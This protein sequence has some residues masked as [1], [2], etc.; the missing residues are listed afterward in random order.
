MTSKTSNTEGIEHSPEEKISEILKYAKQYGTEKIVSSWLSD[1]KNLEYALKDWIGFLKVVMNAGKYEISGLVFD[2]LSKQK[3]TEQAAVSWNSFAFVV[4][5]VGNRK[6]AEKWFGWLNGPE[7]TKQVAKDW[8]EFQFILERA[9][10]Y[11]LLDSLLVY[12]SVKKNL[13]SAAKD[14]K[15][16]YEK[17]EDATVRA[18]ILGYSYFAGI[19]AWFEKNGLQ[20]SDEEKNNVVRVVEKRLRA[21]KN[22]KHSALQIVRYLPSLRATLNGLG[23]AKAKRFVL[24]HALFYIAVSQYPPEKFGYFVD[25]LESSKKRLKK[26]RQ[27]GIKTEPWNNYRAKKTVSI[28]GKKAAEVAL[29][30]I[31]SVA[32]HF[33]KCLQA[34]T[35]SIEKKEEHHENG[36][37]Q[38][39]E[40]K[41]WLLKQASLIQNFA[42]E[43]K[44]PIL[45]EDNKKTYLEVIYRYYAERDVWQELPE[46]ITRKYGELKKNVGGL[47]EKFGQK[48]AKIELAVMTWERKIPN[49]IF[50]SDVCGDCTCTSGNHAEMGVGRL[51]DTGYS[52]LK[53]CLVDGKKAL[54]IGNIYS[55]AYTADGVSCLAIDGVEVTRIN[56]GYGSPEVA[57]T[58][59]DFAKGY[60]ETCNF[61]AVILNEAPSN[62]KWIEGFVASKYKKT[63]VDLHKIGGTDHLY[64]IGLFEREK[65][66]SEGK[67]EVY[68]LK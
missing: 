38:Q 53:I 6:I 57:E 17:L 18:D 54:H 29:G 55:M 32:A 62:S 43:Q 66:F 33:N 63:R 24:K 11:G 47:L 14:W 13:D 12:L 4:Y 5:I 68:K 30:E 7:R 61:K 28:C 52:I 64:E 35:K 60:A 34:N 36:P 22:L 1:K 21:N 10:G 9:D 56:F 67:N 20:L 19:F 8:Q 65:V 3:N 42:K 37:D 16:V 15:E 45:A 26:M 46:F 58:L 27:F 31:K 59:I 50:I 25:S 40:P 23:D 48:Q 39:S 49:D 51:A 44:L 41:Y 2:W